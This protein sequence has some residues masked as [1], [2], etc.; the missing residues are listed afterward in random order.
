[1]SENSGYRTAFKST[2]VFGGVSV[3]TVLI[4]I[5]KS[6]LV[7]IW[8]G[9][10]GFG[11][12]SIYNTV[13]SL[14]STVTNLG[15][16]GSAVRDIAAANASGDGKRLAAVIK[17]TIRWVVA[18]GVL[19]GLVVVAL[20]PVLSRLLFKSNEY[21]LPL[22]LLSS[23]VFLTGLYN[24]HYAILQGTR[25]IR[26]MAKANVFG[27]VAGFVCSVPCFYFFRESGIIWAL[28]L[29]AIATTAISIF[30]ARKVKIIEVKQ[31]IKESFNTGLSTVKLGVMMTLASIVSVIIE[32]VT[33]AFIT[34]IGGVVDVGLYQAGWAINASYLG[35]VFTSMSKDY[36]PRLSGLSAKNNQMARAANEQGEIAV[37]IIAPLLI[38]MVVFVSLCVRIL[39]SSEFLAVIPMIRWLLIGSLFRAGSYALSYIYLA[40]GDGKQYIINELG[41]NF[42]VSLPA[43]LLCY[44]FFGLVGIGYAFMIVYV[45][46]FLWIAM[47]A[48]HN[49]NIQYSKQFWRIFLIIALP[50][51]IYGVYDSLSEM[52]LSRYIVG[53]AVAIGTTIYS[54]FELKKRLFDNEKTTDNPVA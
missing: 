11:I 52:T 12:I 6:K 28:I 14:V 35:M 5:A 46:Y 45:V 1:M 26:L 44:R 18:T 39:Y 2:A 15:L 13:V 22:A 4:G 24:Q 3:I 29:S 16:H 30:Y 38:W 43:Y 40:K 7:A 34:R 25:R 27:S 49:Y 47:R 36:F 17:A 42:F 48:W 32:F 37:L 50:V 31:S 10:A 54:L 51:V 23:V 20:S 53:I 33:K 8:L 9:A 19:G 41:I 21:V